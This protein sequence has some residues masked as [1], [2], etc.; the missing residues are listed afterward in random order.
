MHHSQTLSRS[1]TTACVTSTCVYEI[2][3]ALTKYDGALPLDF[4]YSSSE[5]EVKVHDVTVMESGGTPK[6]VKVSLQGIPIL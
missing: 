5:E 2:A 4:P 1:D 3:P 6:C